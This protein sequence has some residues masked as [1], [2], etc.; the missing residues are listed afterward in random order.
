MSTG[1]LLV[2]LQEIVLNMISLGLKGPG[3]E[4]IYSIP[5]TGHRARVLVRT[6]WVW[7]RIRVK[8]RA[9]FR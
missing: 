3:W 6:R 1:I 4:R 9:S 8:T 7:A 2:G 5:D